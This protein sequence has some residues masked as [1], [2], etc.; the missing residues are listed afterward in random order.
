MREPDATTVS[1]NASGPAARAADAATLRRRG[2]Q[3]PVTGPDTITVPGVVAGWERLHAHG[4]RLPWAD[5]LH[6]AAALA[7]EGVV[8][9]P[10]LGDA[11]GET[12]LGDLGLRTVFA[13]GGTPLATGDLLR[14]PALAATLGRLA[15]D[16]PRAFYEGD[17]GERLLAGLAARGG[18]LGAA[19]L[20]GFAAEVAAPLHA[21][22]A[23]VDVLTSPPNSSGVVLLQA[24][25]ALDAA[26]TPEPLGPDAGVLA[27]I[28]RV[29]A[30]DRDRLLGD[31]RSVEV[32][33]AAWLARGRLEA[34]VER[35]RAAASGDRPPAALHGNRRPTG[36]T[37]A[38]VTADAGGRAVS[39]IQSLFHF[40]GAGILEPDTGVLLH[41]RG[42]FFSLR[43]GHPNELAPGRRPVHTL[44]PM[45]V[46]RDGRLLGVLGTMGG[47]VQAQ[48]LVQ[49]L[50]R[51]LGGDSPQ[52]AVDAPRWIAGGM[53][54]GEL[55]D[56]IRIEDG[57][58]AAARA[59]LARA[60][61]RVFD[62]PRD[63]EWLGHAQALW[64]D[65]QLSA[66]SDRRAD[67]TAAVG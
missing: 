41:N 2:A 55:D 52:E 8:V 25:A 37:V 24:L 33:S 62:L 20:H 51:L 64:L 13:P 36:D 32:D 42:A 27:E 56:T 66:G 49:V 21:R 54:M 39:L 16:G 65:P 61:L 17:V 60:R 50:L 18:L 22:F 40:F 14:Q 44:M 9:A 59:A 67:G 11:I 34:V 28:L 7:E 1:V 19:D 4:A 43:E 45:T 12:D 58:S 5:A 31:P 38:V 29:G 23:G 46:E 48:I 47:K 3:M 10:S 6:A 63:S 57:C 53:E 35:A 15:A 30:E 26:G